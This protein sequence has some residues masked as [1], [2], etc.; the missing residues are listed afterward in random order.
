M[1]EVSRNT[2][3]FIY[4]VQITTEVTAHSDHFVNDILPLIIFLIRRDRI[5]VFV[6]MMAWF[7]VVFKKISQCK[8][9]KTS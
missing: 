3:K 6:Y 2:H 7:G 1:Q 8:L 5:I 9:L 4:G